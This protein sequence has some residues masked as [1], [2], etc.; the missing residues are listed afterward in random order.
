MTADESGSFIFVAGEIPQ[1]EGRLDSPEEIRDMQE[2]LYDRYEL[3]LSDVMQDAQQR[4]DF[5]RAL[6]NG[7]NNSLY[8]QVSRGSLSLNFNVDGDFGPTS[9]L[10]LAYLQYKHNQ[11]NGTE[12]SVDGLFGSETRAILDAL[13]AS[14]NEQD[15]LA[16]DTLMNQPMSMV[17]A[18]QVIE[19]EF[20]GNNNLDYPQ[21][22]FNIRNGQLVPMAGQENLVQAFAYN[23]LRQRNGSN[24]PENPELERVFWQAVNGERSPANPTAGV[25]EEATVRPVEAN[26]RNMNQ[27]RAEELMDYERT[28]RPIIDLIR[29]HTE[30]IHDVESFA[31]ILAE[32]Y[33]VPGVENDEEAILAELNALGITDEQ[34]DALSPINFEWLQ[35]F[36]IVDRE[37]LE[38][39]NINKLRQLAGYLTTGQSEVRD[40][41]TDTQAYA[42]TRVDHETGEILEMT[43]HDE[44]VLRHFLDAFEIDADL[45]DGDLFRQQLIFFR[46]NRREYNRLQDCVARFDDM[47]LSAN[48]RSNAATEALEIMQTQLG[49][50]IER[51]EG[52]LVE[53]HLKDTY[54]NRD[55]RWGRIAE[56]F[57]TNDI[58]GYNGKPYQGPVR[59]HWTNMRGRGEEWNIMIRSGNEWD[60]LDEGRGLGPDRLRDAIQASAEYQ[61]FM[62]GETLS[63][64]VMSQVRAEANTERLQRLS[65]GIRMVQRPERIAQIAAGDPDAIRVSERREGRAVSRVE[66][67]EG[68]ISVREFAGMPRAEY[69]AYAAAN[70]RGAG[71][72]T[73]VPAPPRTSPGGFHA[74]LDVAESLVSNGTHPNLYEA[75][76]N[77][78]PQ[79]EPSGRSSLELIAL[80]WHEHYGI[81]LQADELQRMFSGREITAGQQTTMGALR[82]EYNTNRFTNTDRVY[83]SGE[84]ARE[85]AGLSENEAVIR[86]N[87]VQMTRQVETEDGRIID[88]TF[89]ADVFMMRH[90]CA[91]PLIVPQ[92]DTVRFNYPVRTTG[93]EEVT[94]Y[95]VGID[96]IPTDVLSSD[97]EI[98]PVILIY[99]LLALV[100]G[101]GGGGVI[102]VPEVPK[103]PGVPVF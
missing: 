23:A 25:T 17:L 92:M 71:Q 55:S 6:R 14:R 2:F 60:R 32:E 100:G 69:E 87:P 42:V 58:E 30:G 81:A 80:G 27:A 51:R 11:D 34:L 41:N 18:T 73:P 20:A 13:S 19:Q 8:D 12:Y 64:E 3:E 59:I 39:P 22:G 88:V 98:N 70:L 97:I 72:L 68:V 76:K 45:I 103:V 99:G 29:S 95:S 52:Q 1:I 94:R 40:I 38:I 9:Q 50:L 93:T 79:G 89:T 31:R 66:S 84:T 49:V 36:D 33:D 57:N 53:S 102:K 15:D 56:N 4:S 47:S 75:L 91:N 54:T 74:N 85:W 61:S 78:T 44:A 43:E 67:R 86:M 5:E 26:D 48:E 21:F 63:E 35:P 96:E 101:G 24:Y 7:P 62:R 16:T 65:A 10:A 82:D 83:A 46:D 37:L 77:T 28:T 90:A